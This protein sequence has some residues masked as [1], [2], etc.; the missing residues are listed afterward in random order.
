MQTVD[1]TPTNE[2]LERWVER[3]V[4]EKDLFFLDK[5][6]LSKIKDELNEVLVIPKKE[7]FNHPSYRQIEL[8]NSYTYWNIASKTQY[9]IVAPPSWIKN[10]EKQKKR[11]I[12]HNQISIGRGLIFP[13]SFFSN[14]SIPQD[15]IFVDEGKEVVVLQYDIWNE[16]PYSIKV[17]AIKAYARLWD[18]WTCCDIPIRIPEHIRKYANNFSIVSGSNCLAATLFAITKQEWMINEWIH[19]ATFKEGLERAN[20]SLVNDEI[21]NGDVITWVNED[22]V[23]QHSS[24]YIGNNLLFNKNGQ[25]FFNPWKIITWRELNEEWNHYEK[26]IYRAQVNH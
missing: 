23:I 20:Y 16:L 26:K 2:Q 25:T 12:L 5:V 8:L 1:I 13:L 4:P 11:K 17:N 19:P 6:E 9:V 24:Y 14:S 7:F 3:F 18:S 10:L 15:H 22:G 21:K